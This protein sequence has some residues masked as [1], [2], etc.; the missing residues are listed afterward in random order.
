MNMVSSSKYMTNKT[1]ADIDATRAAAIASGAKLWPKLS[2]HYCASP[3]G[4][5][6]LWCRTSCADE[7]H[8]EVKSLAA[9][10]TGEVSAALDH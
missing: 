8:A 6:A 7:Y 5:G 10:A 2:C 3:L 9:R 4:R 1:Q